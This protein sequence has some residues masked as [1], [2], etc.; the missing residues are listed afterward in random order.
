VSVLT[1]YAFEYEAGLGYLNRELVF[2][3]APVCAGINFLIIAFVLLIFGFVWRIHGVGRKL[4]WFIAAAGIS[5]VVGIL[6]NALRITAALAVRT[7]AFFDFITPADAHRLVGVVVYVSA[8]WGLYAATESLLC[9]SH[10]TR[11]FRQVVLLL[12]TYLGV[13]LVIPLLNGALQQAAYTRHALIVVLASLSVVLG[14]QALAFLTSSKLKP[15][16][17]KYFLKRSASFVLERCLRLA[18]NKVRP[19]AERFAALRQTRNTSS[20]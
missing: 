16:R 12:S 4:L 20:S 7:S 14:F 15:K 13:T 17:A 3:I 5:L 8:L 18:A 11:G 19:A 10:R 6:V 2:V 9:A 1:G